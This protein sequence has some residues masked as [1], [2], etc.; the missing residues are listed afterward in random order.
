M[1]FGVTPAGE[2]P[3]FP[4]GPADVQTINFIVDPLVWTVTRGVGDNGHVATLRITGGPAVPSLILGWFTAV[5]DL[6]STPV[7]TNSGSETWNLT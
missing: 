4:A 3:V 5:H 1:P 7:S 6:G 2:Q